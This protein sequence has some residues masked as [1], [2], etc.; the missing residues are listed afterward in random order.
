MVITCMC[1]QKLAYERFCVCVCVSRLV[2][3]GARECV[4]RLRV[5]KIER[6]RE[7]VRACIWGWITDTHTHTRCV[8]EFECTSVLFLIASTWINV[9][10]KFNT[11]S[12]EIGQQKCLTKLRQCEKKNSKST[13]IDRHWSNQ[14][15]RSFWFEDDNSDGYMTHPN[16]M[17]AR[18]KENGKRVN[19][20]V[21]IL[22]CSCS[23]G[24][25]DV[26][27]TWQK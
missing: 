20:V 22:M 13:L 16:A 25:Y 6:A 4:W 1:A 7:R 26:W 24:A 17:T 23:I 19:Q 5:R 10:F 11:K 18:K 21:S 12:H 27:L 9:P 14:Y 2:N 3:I 8:G 15:V